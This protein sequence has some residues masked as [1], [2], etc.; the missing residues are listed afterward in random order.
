MRRSIPRPPARLVGATVV[1]VLAAFLTLVLMTPVLSSPPHVDDRPLPT[2]SAASGGCTG[3]GVL[4]PATVTLVLIGNSTPLPSVVGVPVTVSYFYTE[5]ELVGTKTTFTCVSTSSYGDT[6]AGG[7][8]SL[9]LPIPPNDCTMTSTVCDNYTGPYGPLSYNTSGPPTGYVEQDLS[10]GIGPGTIDWAAELDAVTLNVTGTVRVSTNAPVEVSAT[11]WNGLGELAPGSLSYSWALDGLGWTPPSQSGP[12]AVVAGLDSGWTGSLVATVTA[13]YGATSESAES[14]VLS[15]IPVPTRV[16][17]AIASATP[18]DPGVPVTFSVTG[19][20]AAGYPYSVTVNP[21]LGAGA[22]SEPCESTQLPNGTANLTCQVQAAYPTEGVALPTASISNGYS[23]GLMDLAPVLVNP[24]EQVTLSAASL[25]SYPD[26]A[27]ALTVSVT[28]G[29]GS[30]PYGPACLSVNGGPPISCL[31]QGGTSWIFDVAFAQAGDYELQA[32]VTD[33]FGEN[34]SA[35][36]GLAVVPFLTV[37]ANGSSS[38]TLYANR[39]TSLSVVV[40]G[41]VLPIAVWW[42]LSRTALFDCPGILDFDGTI[43]CPYEPL[44]VGRANLTVTLRDALGSETS[45]VFRLNVTAAP[46]RPATPGSSVFTGTFGGILFG[47]LAAVAVGILFAVWDVRRRRQ[48]AVAREQENR[49]EEIELER[50]ARG[51]D[52]LLAQADLTDPRRSDELVAGWTGPPVAPEEWAEWIA[53]LVADGSLIP[54]RAPDRRLVYRR[55]APRPSTP[56]IEFDPKALE[57]ARGPR[58][59]ALDPSG[60]PPEP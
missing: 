14:P 12:N 34:V 7:S 31:S 40:A 19:S 25:V 51:R 42:N 35:S 16:F 20:G 30:A 11:A 48:S 47:T 10:G 50:M 24:V 33:R 32:S 41:G 56:T 13:M 29:T 4:S 15:L 8:L 21:G 58:D 53:A 27:I 18:V 1:A 5:S 17:S 44:S 22:V 3:A 2:V 59:E 54:S 60:G 43:A 37:R 26:R 49:V 52:H 9:A 36:A 45:V 6:G 28:N 38:L 55:A 23:T 39:T 46:V 57:A